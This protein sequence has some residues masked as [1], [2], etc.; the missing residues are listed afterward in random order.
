MPLTNGIFSGVTAHECCRAVKVIIAVLNIDLWR[1]G[2]GTSW[3]AQ[4]NGERFAMAIVTLSTSHPVAIY[5]TASGGL[6]D[7]ATYCRLSYF[8]KVLVDS[9]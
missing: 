3:P 6:P 2:P 1:G 8:T 9:A 5:L 4:R 7:W